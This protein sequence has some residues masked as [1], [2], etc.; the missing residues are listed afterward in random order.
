MLRTFFRAKS[1]HQINKSSKSLLQKLCVRIVIYLE[2]A[3]LMAT[4]QEELLIA[5]DKLI[6]LLLNLGFL[7]NNQKL[8]LDRPSTL[9]FVAVLLD[10]QNITLSL[11]QEKVGKIKTQCTELLQ[12]SLAWV[13]ELRKLIGLLYFTV[14]QARLQYRALHHQKIQEM[15]SK[16]SIEGQ[17]SLKT[18]KGRVTLVDAKSQPIQK[19]VLNFSPSSTDNKFR[20][21]SP[22]LG[23]SFQGQTTVGP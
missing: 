18:G 19:E 15:I 3:I 6:F 4:S 2:D 8:I 22:G 1:F 11:A 16:S 10:S 7:I 23:A 9:E 13:R 21:I 20:C 5:W 17:F 14:L 12:K